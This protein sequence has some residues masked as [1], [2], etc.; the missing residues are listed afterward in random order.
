ML[1][2]IPL[3][4]ICRRQKHQRPCRIVCLSQEGLEDQKHKAK[5]THSA[6]DHYNKRNGNNAR[7]ISSAR[8][9]EKSL[10]MFGIKI[11]YFERQDGGLGKVTSINRYE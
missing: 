2:F 1:H 7:K 8:I 6:N 3:V 10:T 9:V 5:S 11:L 4:C